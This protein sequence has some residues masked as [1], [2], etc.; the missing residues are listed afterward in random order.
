MKFWKIFAGLGLILAAVLLV[1]DALGII[2]PIVSVVGEITLFEIVG[3]LIIIAL[4]IERLIRG[5]IPSIFFFLAFLFMLFEENIAYVCGLE[6]ENIIS[7]WL[8]LLIALLLTVGFSIL[9]S[10]KKR[11]KFHISHGSRGGT[12]EYSGKY[13]ESN[14]GA[15]AI[16]VDCTTFSPSHIENNLG[17]C[18]VHFQNVESFKG[19]ETLYVENN[20]GSICIHVP[21][22]W[23]V[24]SS[25]ENN[26]GGTNVA[27]NELESDLV[28]YVKGENNLGSLSIKYI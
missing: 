18:S 10:S 16:Y 27:S 9:F 4:I 19:G 15:S 8:V 17:S 13:A 12:L 11:K 25:I 14:L 22:E 5:K 6:N 23:T 7:N 1:L 21:K 20:L 3:G 28:L 2:T 24:K 26:L